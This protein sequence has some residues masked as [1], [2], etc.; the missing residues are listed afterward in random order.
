MDLFP[1]SV[2]VIFFIPNFAQTVV[3]IFNWMLIDKEEIIVLFLT[4]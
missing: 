4:L 1:F 2:P 3:Q